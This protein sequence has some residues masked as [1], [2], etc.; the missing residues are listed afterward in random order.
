LIIWSIVSLYR[1]QNQKPLLI[2]AFSLAGALLSH[3][4]LTFLFLPFL[5]ALIIFS[6]WQAKK[7]VSLALSYIKLGLLFLGL[8]AYYWLPA[9][10]EKRYTMFS[11]VL[12]DF[13]VQHFPTLRQLIYSPWGYG[14]SHPGTELFTFLA[15]G[16]KEKMGIF[17]KI[18]SFFCFFFF[19]CRFLYDF[20]V[21]A[22]LAAADLLF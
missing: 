4:M 15:M 1:K 10:I 18:D 21:K 19:C 12:T 9:T 17:S 14:F 20:S 7:K 16:K 3:A 8:S 5:A 22:L 11:H 2:G 6:L 13:Y